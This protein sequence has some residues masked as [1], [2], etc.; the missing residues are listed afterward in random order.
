MT[1]RYS[2]NHKIVVANGAGT[3]TLDAGVEV[4]GDLAFSGTI[5]GNALF[6]GAVTTTTQV[7]LAATTAYTVSIPIVDFSY[8]FSVLNAPSTD[9]SNNGSIFEVENNR[10]YFY[11][12]LSG[13]I[14][15]G[16]AIDSIRMISYVSN[17]AN[18]ATLTIYKQDHTSATADVMKTLG[19]K[20][21]LVLTDDVSAGFVLNNTIDYATRFYFLKLELNSL[22]GGAAT[23][24][25]CSGVKITY[26]TPK[27]GQ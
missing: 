15:N 16:A 22:A 13:R 8:A 17:A 5:T 24:S 19:P 25:F 9:F 12:N 14:P 23:S 2:D 6:T 1:D 7:T 21:N 11:K 3:L 26:M 27:L 10:L 18:T 20:S 4:T